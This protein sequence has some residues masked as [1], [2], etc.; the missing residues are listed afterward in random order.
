MTPRHVAIIG[1]ARSGKDTLG[2]R[3]VTAH[4][5]T[6]V[7]FAD[8]LKDTALSLDPIVHAEAGHFGYLPVRLSALVERV[9][10]E[11]AKALPEVRRLLQ[12]LGQGVRDL[13]P[14][15]W[16]RLALRKVSVA[17]T[18]NL[19]VVV[20]D[21]RYVNEA[22]A[23]RSAGFTLVRVVR[24]GLSQPGAE[25]VSETELNDFAA[26]AVIINSGSV[27]DLWAQADALL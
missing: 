20:T 1:R 5:Y 26:D 11:Q 9:G 4:Q 18:W 27:H 25:H 10:W 8:P 17:N 24:P 21:C 23:L 12:H 22:Q 15:T 19:P 16:L 14:G 6:R 13:D 3:L 2:A 7:A